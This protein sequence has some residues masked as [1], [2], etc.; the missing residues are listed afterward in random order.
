[1][2]GPAKRLLA[3]PKRLS[4]SLGMHRTLVLNANYTPLGTIDWKRAIT[5]IFEGKVELVE[6]YEDFVVRSP[7]TTMK[8]P[9]V[10]RVIK[11]VKAKTIGIRFNKGNVFLRDKGKCQ[12]CALSS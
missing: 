2:D 5:L 12:Y 4:Y 3:L 8:V 6:E 1:M 10:I 9:S 7:S 11:W